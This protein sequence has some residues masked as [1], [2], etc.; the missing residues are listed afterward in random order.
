[1]AVGIPSIAAA[2][3]LPRA[4]QKRT[5]QSNGAGIMSNPIMRFVKSTSAVELGFI[6][7]GLTVA[8]TAC[9]GTLF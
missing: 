8:I 9:V 1:M 6:S 5:L 7:A 4:W 3:R 2:T